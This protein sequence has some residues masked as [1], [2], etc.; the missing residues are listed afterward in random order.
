MKIKATKFN[1]ITLLVLLASV[2]CVVLPSEET[3][4]QR[5]FWK[6]MITQ[7]KASNLIKNIINGNNEQ[8]KNYLKKGCTD[9]NEPDNMQQY[10]PLHWA[11]LL[12]RV[13]IVKAILACENID[14]NSRDKIG[15]T[16]LIVA[17]ISDNAG[18]VNLLREHNANSSLKDC[19]KQTAYDYQLIRFW[20]YLGREIRMVN[21]FTVIPLPDKID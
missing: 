2:I 11:V 6:A 15:R 21:T 13:E 9:I 7:F 12:D 19:D 8:V 17:T 3:E 10:S 18:A 14:I 1:F 20:R 4:L 5:N 16:P